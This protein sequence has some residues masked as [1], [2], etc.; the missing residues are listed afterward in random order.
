LT[1]DALNYE[2]LAGHPQLGQ[3]Q[4]V[5]IVQNLSNEIMG[6][7]GINYQA[8]DLEFKTRFVIYNPITEKNLYNKAVRITANAV[9]TRKGSVPSTEVIYTSVSKNGKMMMTEI[10]STASPLTGSLKWFFRLLNRVSLMTDK[11]AD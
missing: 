4:P 2:L 8:Q 9:A 10:Q 11:S 6:A 5:A 7:S 3:I 1:E